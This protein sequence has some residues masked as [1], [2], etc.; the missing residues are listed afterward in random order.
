MAYLMRISLWLCMACVF[1]RQEWNQGKQKAMIILHDEVLLSMVMIKEVGRYLCFI[2]CF[3]SFSKAKPIWFACW[4]NVACEKDNLRTIPRF[5]LELW[6]DGD[7]IEQKG[8]YKGRVVWR[9]C[10]SKISYIPVKL[11]CLLGIYQQWICR[12]YHLG[13]SLKP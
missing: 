7:T 12:I 10:K 11:S 6:K 3:V 5:W 9:K 13:K 1:G 2:L 8:K 4:L